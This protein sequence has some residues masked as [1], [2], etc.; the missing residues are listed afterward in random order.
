MAAVDFAPF[1]Q[2]FGE[3]T[4]GYVHPIPLLITGR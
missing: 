2:S 4:F 1:Y 3:M